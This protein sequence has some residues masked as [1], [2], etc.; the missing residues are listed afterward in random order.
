MVA[1]TILKIDHWSSDLLSRS[2][3]EG[4][5]N[6]RHIADSNIFAVAQPTLS[7]MKNV[8]K[9]VS[10]IIGSSVKDFV[11]INLREE[12]IIYINGTPFVLRD[13]YYTL[14]NIKSYSGINETRLELLENRLKE[15][16]NKELIAYDGQILLHEESAGKVVMPSWVAAETGDIR[17]LKELVDDVRNQLHDIDLHSYRIPVTAEAAPEPS[18]FDHLM[19]L[20]GR[21]DYRK[22]AYI[23]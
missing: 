18:D 21:Y 16:I 4:A 1:Q 2:V 13:H 23:L 10:S 8:L 19:K 20:V 6:F 17:T 22:T 11:W 9:A 14:R 5:P 7:G 3:I 12:P 15:D